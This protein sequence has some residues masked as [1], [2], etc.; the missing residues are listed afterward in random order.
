VAGYANCTEAGT[1][2]DSKNKV[3]KEWRAFGY[4]ELHF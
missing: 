3:G 4:N 1:A 2:A